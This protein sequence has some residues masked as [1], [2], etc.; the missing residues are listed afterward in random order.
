VLVWKGK[1][2]LEQHWSSRSMSAGLH[3]PAARTTLSAWCLVPSAVST[4]IHVEP[5]VSRM[6]FLKV[7]A[8]PKLN[9]TPCRLH[10]SPM[11]LMALAAASQPPSLLKTAFQPYNALY[12]P[13]RRCF[14]SYG[15]TLIFSRSN[16]GIFCSISSSFSS[17][18]V[19]SSNPA[20]ASRSALYACLRSAK[21]SS[22]CAQSSYF[23]CQPLIALWDIPSYL[24]EE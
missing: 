14:S 4:P 24:S 23:L 18:S 19:L 15:L 11:A 1:R 5:S 13:H 16:S 7:P 2:T 20:P 3:A 21:P 8:P 6:G 12:Q 17:H 10:S 9:L 22:V